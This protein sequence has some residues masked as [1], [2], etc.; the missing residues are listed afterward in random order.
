MAMAALS[1][2][3][4]NPFPEPRLVKFPT[5]TATSNS[6]SSMTYGLEDIKVE[7][8][9]VHVVHVELPPKTQISKT[10]PK[11]YLKGPQNVKKGTF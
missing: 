2:G 3:D 7:E 10:S 8:L 11:K 9:L 5:S 4:D 1:G 6:Q